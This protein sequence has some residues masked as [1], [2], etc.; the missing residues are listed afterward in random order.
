M[1]STQKQY[2]TYIKQW[3]LFNPL[4]PSVNET[5]AFLESLPKNNITPTLNDGCFLWN[6]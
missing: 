1:E 4:K 3:L 6:Q 5:L 2:N